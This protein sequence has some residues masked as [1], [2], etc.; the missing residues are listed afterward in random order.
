MT[1]ARR[2]V[3]V[4]FGP[5]DGDTLDFTGLPDQPVLVTTDLYDKATRYPLLARYLPATGHSEERPE[6][7]DILV[8]DGWYV[9]TPGDKYGPRV[10]G[11]VE[12]E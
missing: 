12:M 9:N 7:R 5:K 10:G 1:T 8:F 4:W 11:M 2:I 3:D 6:P